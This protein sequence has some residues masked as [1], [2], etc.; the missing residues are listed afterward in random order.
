VENVFEASI[1]NPN[2]VM[3]VAAI[4]LT[5][6]SPVI[7]V[8]PV[9]DIPDFAKMT[10]LPADPRFTA[11]G[12]A[13]SVTLGPMRLSTEATVNTIAEVSLNFFISD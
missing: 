1:V 2:P 12:P 11:A 13:A 3:A 9:V 4:G 6:I 7:K 8:D 5:P 10:K